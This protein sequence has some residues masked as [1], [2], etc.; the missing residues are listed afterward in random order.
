MLPNNHKSGAVKEGSL[1]QAEL[2]DPNNNVNQCPQ[3][4]PI[5]TTSSSYD[6]AVQTIFI[7]GYNNKFS[8][9]VDIFFHGRSN[10]AKC[11]YVVLAYGVP[12]FHRQLDIWSVNEIDPGYSD[13]SNAETTVKILFTTGSI[14]PLRWL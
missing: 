11:T 7:V 3:A 4:S 10:N 12:Y 5:C 9:G 1:S 8:P 14:G 2:K 6:L 13:G